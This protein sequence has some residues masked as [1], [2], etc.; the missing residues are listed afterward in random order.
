MIKNNDKNKSIVLD[1]L[2]YCKKLARISQKHG[3]AGRT[4]TDLVDLGYQLKS[5]GFSWKLY[6]ERAVTLLRPFVWINTRK[7][8]RRKRFRKSIERPVYLFKD[9][10]LRRS[11]RMLFR[12]PRRTIGVKNR[13]NFVGRHLA[14][15]RDIVGRGFSVIMNKNVERYK[16]ARSLRFSR[17]KPKYYNLV[18]LGKKFPKFMGRGAGYKPIPRPGQGK[19][20][21]T[22]RKGLNRSPTKPK[23]SSNY[24]GKNFNSSVRV[25]QSSKNA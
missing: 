24:K 4:F 13:V 2:L 18:K 11:V 9:V 17:R 22:L 14:F 25:H 21:N 7:T 3:L 1:K 23:V 12:S 16:L 6:V 8:G 19:S 5:A 15:V 20:G 10:A